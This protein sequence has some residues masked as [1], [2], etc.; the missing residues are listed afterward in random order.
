MTYG[1]DPFTYEALPTATSIRLIRV[2]GTDAEGRLQIELKTADLQDNPWYHAISYTWGNPHSE[3][4]QLQEQRAA[5]AHAHP[6]H[7]REDLLINGKLL[8]V[9]RGAYDALTAASA[10]DI[11]RQRCNRGNPKKQLRTTV[12][13]AALSAHGSDSIKKMISSG[14]DVNVR[15]AEGVTPLGCAAWLGNLEAVEMLLA[16]GADYRL[17][18]NSQK[19]A[20]DWARQSRHEAVIRRL[21]QVEEEGYVAAPV[22]WPDGPQEWC[23][24]DQICINQADLTERSSHVAMMDEV[25]AKA[26]FTLVWLGPEDPYT[27]N[28]ISAIDKL[29][30][31]TPFHET[32]LVPYVSQ[33]EEAYAAAGV[34]WVSS[35]EWTALAAFLQRPYFR[36]LWIVQESILSDILIGLCGR[37]EVPWDR[38]HIVAQHLYFR[39]QMLG[40][41]TSTAYINPGNAV[42]SLESEVVVLTQWRERLQKG[43]QAAVP[44]ALSLENLVFDTWTFRSTDP[45][46]KIFGLY[47]LLSKAGGADGPNWRPDYRKSTAQVFAET[48]RIIIDEGREL[49]MLSAVLDHSLRRL[50]NLPSWVPDYSVPFVNMMYTAQRAAGDLTLPQPLLQPSPW[51]VLRIAG[52]RVDT[53]LRRGESTSGPG[54]LGMFFDPRWFELALLL[55]QPYHG[56]SRTEALWRTLCTD[57]TAKGVTPAPDEYGKHFRAMLCVLVCIYA[58]EATARAREESPDA[59]VVD[60]LS[61]MYHVRTVMERPPLS[62][63]TR[64]ELQAAFQEPDTNL[65]GPEFQT[66]THLLY[67]LD[68]L[69][70][71]E[72]DSWTPNLP[73]V[74]TTYRASDS[75]VPWDEYR[76]SPLPESGQEFY[77]VL[78][79]RRG[80]RRLFVTEK[81]YLGLGPAAMADGDQIWVFPGAGTALVLRPTPDKAFHFIGE[82]YIHGGMNGELVEG[83][84]V[85]DLQTV[86]LV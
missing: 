5:Y 54:Q 55:P 33:S 18:D 86:D 25:Y 76:A 83:V 4:T 75:W 30:A 32:D 72:D 24:V 69:W 80:R 73:E 74:W 56:Q 1:L 9:G 62:E 60:L 7:S 31:G 47:G 27:A 10:R 68:I 52:T 51:N 22:V 58:A 20:L 12:H 15:D 39:Q 16:A 43:E 21:E 3:W 6:P 84:A 65:S 13:W 66:L 2:H 77:Q 48:T 78:R 85:E 19:N 64:A 71:T 81:R 50:E 59:E 34:P 46:D 67:K 17:R 28:A 29:Y 79:S 40:R 14:A 53:V 70:R 26:T 38:F 63:M 82:A 37:H 45:R 23:W 61:A 44:R 11:W 57:Q 49:R 8:R 41:V 35:E 36:R 42:A